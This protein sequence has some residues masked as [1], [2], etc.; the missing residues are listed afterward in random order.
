MAALTI[1]ATAGRI[2]SAVQREKVQGLAFRVIGAQTVYVGP[3]GVTAAS[4]FPVETGETFS[5]DLTKDDQLWAVTA[6]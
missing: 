2:D 1:T 5:A 4:G 6:S 3:Q